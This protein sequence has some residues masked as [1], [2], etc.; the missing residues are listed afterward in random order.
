ME[1][2]F[3]HLYILNDMYVL[4]MYKN[5]ALSCEI[6]SLKKVSDDKNCH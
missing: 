2:K 5:K 6:L 3:V 1:A 4:K